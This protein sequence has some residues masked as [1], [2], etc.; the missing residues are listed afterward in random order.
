[1]EP[2][3][4][5]R[6]ATAVAPLADRACGGAAGQIDLEIAHTDL[7]YI[8]LETARAAGKGDGIDIVSTTL[9]FEPRTARSFGFVADVV[10]QKL[11]VSTTIRISGLGIIDEHLDGRLTNLRAS[12]EGVVG[13]IACALLQPVL[14]D[15]ANRSLP[16]TGFTGVPVQ[17]TDIHVDVGP[18]LAIRAHVIRTSPRPI[19]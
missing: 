7:E 4:Q 1:M 5:T 11:F 9:A 14:D 16:L 17:V 3:N 8:L 18:P 10:A 12:G 13:K 6:L 2:D 19:A 15:Y